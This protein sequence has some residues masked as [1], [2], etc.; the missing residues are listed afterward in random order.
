MD[1][2]EENRKSRASQQVA[3]VL[4]SDSAI[5]TQSLA[6][7]DKTIR[8]NW[9]RNAADAIQSMVAPLGSES[10]E[11]IDSKSTIHYRLS[12]N[13]SNTHSSTDDGDTAFGTEFSGTSG[14]D[15]FSSQSQSYSIE[16]ASTG[17][18]EPTSPG[19]GN[20]YGS[21]PSQSQSYS[22]A[23]VS[24]EATEPTTPGKHYGSRPSQSQ[25]Y[26]IASVSTDATQPTS[27]GRPY[28]YG[29]RPTFSPGNAS[30]AT[31]A[32]GFTT[33]GYSSEEVTSYDEDEEED[34]EEQEEA[35][36]T[37]LPSL[38][39][40]GTGTSSKDSPRRWNRIPG[41][42]AAKLML[43]GPHN[44]QF[45][46]DEEEEAL[47]DGEIGGVISEEK[48]SEADSEV[49]ARNTEEIEGND[50]LDDLRRAPSQDSVTSAVYAENLKELERTHESTKV[51]FERGTGTN[52]RY[53]QQSQQDIVI[54]D[55][56]EEHSA[57]ANPAAIAAGP[58]FMNP[59][60][61][62]HETTEAA[63]ASLLSPRRG[64]S[65]FISNSNSELGL[66]TSSSAASAFQAPRI[67]T[68]FTTGS[69]HAAPRSG[70]SHATP[71]TPM[72]PFES[73][74]R[75]DVEQKLI[76]PETEKTL[77]EMP[78]K[79]HDPNKTLTDLLTAIASLQDKSLMDLGYMVRRKNACGALQVLTANVK[80]RERICWTVGVLPAL[81][82]V[83]ADTCVD[84][85]KIAFADR[86]IRVEFVEARKRAIAALTNLAMPT[87]N[88][89]PVFH[90]P[91]L[92][93]WIV[94]VIME[95]SGAAQRGCC[96]ILA[97][98]A[99]SPENRLLLVQ[100]PGLMDALIKVLR[101]RPPRLESPS[102]PT[103]KIYPWSS[104]DESFS[105]E[106]EDKPASPA[107]CKSVSFKDLKEDNECDSEKTP[108]VGGTNPPLELVGYDATADEMLRGARQNVFALLSHLTKEKDNAYH[109]ARD[110]ALVLAMVDI[111]KFDESPSHTLAIKLL[112]NLTRHRLN[113]KIVVFKQQIIVPA[114]V[115]A[116]E[117]TNDETRL[118]ACYALQ[119]L[120]QDKSCRQ[121]LAITNNLITALCN[122]S[123]DARA[124]EERLAAVSA[125]KNLCDE[126]ANLIPLTNTHDCIST[127]MQLAHGNEE[128][129]SETTQYRACDGL[130]TL[131]HWL[132]KIATSGKTLDD[133]KRGKQ[134]TKELFIPS[135]QVVTW[136]QWQ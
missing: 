78:K 130:A 101:P 42:A 83:L 89:V 6:E 94:V 10:L 61:N 15:I 50:R 103:K 2:I 126:P 100:V 81:T 48:K 85:P 96:A 36:E 47:K 49:V 3:T 131:S 66:V 99:K 43:M 31:N 23:S 120:S 115:V 27:P 22:I 109:F 106:D 24:S 117:A 58:R 25:S 59:I 97:Y 121:E 105:S 34:D 69:S 5:T 18:T 114:L 135:L 7:R 116:A 11:S 90:T 87:K 98:L 104:D 12:L 70:T 52:R 28:A 108:R 57:E 20:P 86:R 136:D 4:S 112:A 35:D 107:S 73:L 124:E 46:E 65:S 45:G 84:G 67:D 30:G 1:D 110:S 60:E 80:N 129:V 76:A 82:S 111:S 71:R 77:R 75:R 128:G 132:R 21:T 13:S 14:E 38:P 16:S 92:I 33:D 95:D 93:Y 54:D 91:D 127:L 123:R 40:L 62:F 122:R 88:R 37:T 134:P 118:Y 41:G 9:E 74:A 68:A 39:S 63:I 44:D 17:A 102:S 119:N 8:G 55:L 29:S 32:S 26:S 133:A 113:T 64:E 56:E 72:L 51:E 53:Q 19:K 125:L 79:M